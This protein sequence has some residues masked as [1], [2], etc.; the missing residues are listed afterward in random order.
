MNWI[1]IQVTERNGWTDLTASQTHQLDRLAISPFVAA[2]H[3]QE[4]LS[5]TILWWENILL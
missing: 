4:G 3:Y 2:K 1:M 5:A